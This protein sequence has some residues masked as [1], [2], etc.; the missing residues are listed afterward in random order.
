MFKKNYSMTGMM[1]S[2]IAIIVIL[3]IFGSHGVLRFSF[4]IDLELIVWNSPI[5]SISPYDSIM[6]AWKYGMLVYLMEISD[7]K[8]PFFS[9]LV[10]FQQCMFKKIHWILTYLDGSTKILYNRSLYVK[11]HY[12]VTEYENG[13]G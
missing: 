7:P 8:Y 13:K 5:N 4:L 12:A 11:V 2:S 6:K 1:H 9:R 3:M 10:K